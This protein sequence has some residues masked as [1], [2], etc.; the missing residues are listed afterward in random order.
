[1]CGRAAA[2]GIAHV[3]QQRAGG[4]DRER[5][6][7]GAEAAQVEGAELIGQQARGAGEI[8]MPGGTL[9]D[10]RASAGRERCIAR[11]VL[12]HQQFRRPQALELGGERRRSRG[13]RVR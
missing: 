5:Q 3:L 4:A 8:K 13:I 6:L 11:L 12:A 10:H 7:V 9:A 2:L 1:M